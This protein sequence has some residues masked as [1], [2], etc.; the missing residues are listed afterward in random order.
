MQLLANSEMVSLRFNVDCNIDLSFPQK[1]EISGFEHESHPII[2]AG[3]QQLVCSNSHWGLVPPDW[4]KKPEDIWNNTISAKLEY[5]NRRYSW[6]KVQQNRC[7]VPVT[8]YF[9]YQWNDPKGNSKTKYIMKSADSELFALAGLFSV[10][11]DEKG[12]SLNTFAVCTTKADE[13]MEL[14]HNKDADK[15]YHRMPVML[16]LGDEQ[17]WLDESV[18]CMDFAFP[19]YQPNL[20]ATPVYISSAQTQLFL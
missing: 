19:E 5:L 16:N 6:Q 9:E 10:W 3:K 13:T 14:I 7:L 8:G 20:V 11:H 1:Q 12:G 18:P 15:N 2:T 4:R 17:K